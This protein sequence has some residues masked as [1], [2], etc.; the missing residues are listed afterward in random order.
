M[1]LLTSE[2][3]QLIKSNTLSW[4]SSFNN[5]IHFDCKLA[6]ISSNINSVKNGLK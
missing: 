3:S 5:N 6:S 1:S 2:I 4:I